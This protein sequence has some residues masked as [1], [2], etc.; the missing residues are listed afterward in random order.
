[1]HTISCRDL[2]GSYR[3]YREVGDGGGAALARGE[4]GISFACAH[5][6]TLELLVSDC[7]LLSEHIAHMHTFFSHDS[8]L[9]EPAKERLLLQTAHDTRCFQ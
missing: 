4:I 3:P 6:I 1:M 2:W 9:P 8:E 5:G 7:N